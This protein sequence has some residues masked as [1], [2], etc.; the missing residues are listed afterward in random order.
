[1]YGHYNQT[2][3]VLF[4][5]GIASRADRASYFSNRSKRWKA[6]V[7]KHGSPDI[8]ILHDKLSKEDACR[9]EIDLIQKHGRRGYD[10]EGQLLNHSIGGEINLGWNHT[11]STRKRIAESGKGRQ[12]SQKF[13]DV[14]LNNNPSKRPEVREKIR[15]SKMGKH[16][17]EETKRKLSENS[18]SRRPEVAQKISEALKGRTG[19]QHCRSV[20]VGC[21]T[22][23]GKLVAEYVGISEA[24]R[25]TGGDFR[26]ISAVCKGKRKTHIG[27]NWKYHE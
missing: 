9:I 5:V 21:Y 22:K 6:Y 3:G 16:R 26:L 11:E 14:M 17:D 7:A 23:D 20:K 24:A 12:P 19:D 4:Y 8:R 13:L 1:M 18:S 27:F 2:T 15:Q 10:P 25:Q